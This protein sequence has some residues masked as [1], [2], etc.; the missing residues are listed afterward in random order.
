MTTAFTATA[1]SIGWYVTQARDTSA[2]LIAVLLQAG[3]ESDGA[4]ADRTTL[5]AVFAHTD[6]AD[7]TNYA[8][9]TLSGPDRVVDSSGDRVKLV[10]NSPITW[11]S[12]GGVTNNTLAKILYCYRPASGSS[13]SQ[14]LPL[15]ATDISATTNGNDLQ[16]TVSDDGFA[17]VNTT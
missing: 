7:F 2:D 10:V 8:P 6:E 12:A 5:A 13:D 3:G 14:I 9:L 11:G 17:V 1:D 4:M 16:V 15:M